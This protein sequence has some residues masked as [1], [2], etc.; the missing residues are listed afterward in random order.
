MI[1]PRPLSIAIGLLIILAVLSGFG[2]WLWRCLK[3]SDDPAKLLFKWLVTLLCLAGLAGLVFG[4][5]EGLGRL[6]V[7]FVC[8][9]IGVVMSIL[10]AP[11]IGALVAKPF[12]SM[13][14]GGDEEIEPQPLYSIAIAKRKAG[15]YQEAIYQVHKQLERFPHDFQGLI[16]LA[17]IQAEDLNDLPGAEM[18]IERLL[19][20]PGHSPS[21][22]ALALNELADWR[23]KYLQ[24]AEAARQ[25]LQR[26]MELCPDSEQAHMAEQRI[27][28]LANKEDL[29]AAHDRIPIHLPAGA[30][31]V[32]LIK[33]SSSLRK[34]VDDPAALAVEYVKHLEMHPGDD[35]AREKLALLYAE[36]Y[37]RADLAI[38]QLEQL[39][40]QPH[41][42]P[43]Q[44][45][46]WLNLIADLQIRYTE[47]P[48]APR[49]TLRRII[50]LYPNLSYAENAQHRLAHLNL[51]L[52]GK[53]KS[54]P[55]KLGS[56]EQNIGLKK[57]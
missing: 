51:Q 30:Q 37:Q 49:Q 8:V 3:N 15:K 9:A 54:Q 35:E 24:D 45:A 32:G 41:R 31:R 4:I 25:A 26:I 40:Q 57:S 28:H 50:E 44:V 11:H 16:M 27:A 43:K 56:Y 6:A 22:M 18:T 12:T 13:F 19:N 48:E 39:A 53:E 17:E 33:D 52:K 14:D 47:D 7:P 2:W 20:Q 42:T 5:E 38:D 23:L 55:I 46:H 10:W 1:M 34:P 21:T 29:L 36:H